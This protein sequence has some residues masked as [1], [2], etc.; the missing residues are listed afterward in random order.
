MKHA[1]PTGRV[2]SRVVLGSVLAVALTHG[3]ESFAAGARGANGDIAKRRTELVQSQALNA[4]VRADRDKDGVLS[5]DELEQYDLSL[6]RR[7]KEAD[8]DR[9]G[10]LN[11]SEFEKLFGTPETSVSR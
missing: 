11:F 6:A 3:E 10:K 2:L 8:A 7:F 4:M 1:C 5:R 9:D